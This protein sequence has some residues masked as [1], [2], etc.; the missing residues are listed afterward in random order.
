LAQLRM[1]RINTNI[2]TVM[3]T[4]RAFFSLHRLGI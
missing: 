3:P 2:F 4:A 1:I